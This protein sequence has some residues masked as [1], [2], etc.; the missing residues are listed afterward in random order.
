M[1]QLRVLDERLLQKRIV[2]LLEASVLEMSAQEGGRE[3]EIPYVMNDALEYWISLSGCTVQGE[4]PSSFSA[5][6]DLE[7]ISDHGRQALVFSLPQERVLTI[8]Y[9]RAQEHI[10]PCQYHRTAHFWREDPPIR[11]RALVNTSCVLFDKRRFAGEELCSPPEREVMALIG[12]APFRYWSPI[13]DSLDAWYADTD[14]GMEA[15]AG[16]CERVGAR[17]LAR[18]MR[19]YR[20]HPWAALVPVLAR[21]LCSPEGERVLEALQEQV[22]QGSLY[23]EARDYGPENSA[24]IAAA[25]QRVERL[26]LQRGFQGSWPDYRLGAQQVHV[27]E[28]QPFTRLEWEGAACRFHLLGLTPERG[29]M[30]ES[31]ERDVAEAVMVR[32]GTPGERTTRGEGGVT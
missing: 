12:C 25:R 3:I 17:R 7:L 14:E 5:Q 11:W 6:S 20:R 27:V 18:Q 16:V 29:R 19:F 10:H 2:T 4:I 13:S 23:W 32:G 15:M 1:G 28:E 9:D 24:R 21:R 31:L 22:R 8:W 26:L 30:R